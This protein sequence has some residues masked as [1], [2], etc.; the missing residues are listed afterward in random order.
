MAQ[1]PVAAV[2][3]RVRATFQSSTGSATNADG[4]QAPTYAPSVQVWAQAQALSTTDLQHVDGLNLQ[5]INRSIYIEGRWEGV[6]RPA[7]KGGDL[8]T[9]NDGSVWLVVAVPED[10]TRFPVVAPSPGQYRRG[11]CRVVATLQDGS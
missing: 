5:G 9:M 2:N 4:T 3:P 1:G 6:D 7:V 11:W 10:W 8:I